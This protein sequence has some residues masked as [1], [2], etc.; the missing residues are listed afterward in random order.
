MAAYPVSNYDFLAPQ[1][2]MFGWGRWPEL[3]RL[4]SV[5]GN[6]AFL[7]VGSR[8]LKAGGLSAQFQ[9]LLDRHHVDAIELATVTGEPE[10]ADV[11]AVAEQLRAHGI[12]A[13][14]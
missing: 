6:R 1:R 8:T 11:D 14:T 7:V 13:A 12:R 9:D 10:V 5:I 2:I 4:A 3:G